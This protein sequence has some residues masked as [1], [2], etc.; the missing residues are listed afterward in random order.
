MSATPAPGTVA[1]LSFAGELATLT[2]A[3]PH[4]SLPVIDL[5][6]LEDLERA[7]GELRRAL[8]S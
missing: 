2:L 7:L 4:R 8:S 5:A 3:A 6:M 1:T